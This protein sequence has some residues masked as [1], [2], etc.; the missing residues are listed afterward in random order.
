[1]KTVAE[2]SGVQY[3]VLSAAEDGIAISRNER[4]K[5]FHFYSGRGLILLGRRDLETDLYLGVGI[6]E[7]FN[8]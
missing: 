7:R 3:R 5:L 4:E 1:M 2:E 8:R 6:M